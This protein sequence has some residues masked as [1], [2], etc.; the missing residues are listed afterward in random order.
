MSSPDV[1]EYGQFLVDARALEIRTRNGDHV[2]V[3][4]QAVR[5]LLIL[6]RRIGE[7]VTR[8]EIYQELW[9]S[10][11]I[12][13][14]RGLN[15][16]VRQL[17]IGLG[18]SATDPRHIRTYPGRGYRLQ[19]AEPILA[20]EA[21]LAR[22]THVGAPAGG[23]VDAGRT[24][25][26]T[27]DGVASLEVVAVTGGALGTRVSRFSSPTRRRRRLALASVGVIA[28]ACGTAVAVADAREP[29]LT[30]QLQGPMSDDD[31][32]TWRA[33]L[34]AEAA[35]HSLAPRVDVRVVPAG[36]GDSTATL[37]LF[38]EV[39]RDTIWRSQVR[40]RDGAGRDDRQ[41]VAREVMAA[42]RSSPNRESRAPHRLVG[43]PRA[44][45][46][47]L[48]AGRHLLR[49]A[50]SQQRARAVP[51][52][53][54][55]VAE[56]PSARGVRSELAE[57]LLW[58]GAVD[59]AHA[60][61]SAAITLDPDDAGSWFI[62]G[63]TAHLARWDWAQAR[64]AIA[65]AIAL[66]PSRAAFHSALAFV[67][68]TAG[69]KLESSASLERAIATGSSDAVVLADVGQIYA[70]IGDA[71][72]AVEYCARAVDVDSTATSALHC[73]VEAQLATGDSTGALS[74]VRR[75][76]AGRSNSA[77]ADGRALAGELHSWRAAQA[78]DARARL[79]GRPGSYFRA[80]LTFNRAG[81]R[82]EALLALREAVARREPY[83]VMAT[84][85]PALRDLIDVPG[86][87]ALVSPVVAAGAAACD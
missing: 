5:L 6:H 85:S 20:P 75:L 21:P 65:R 83:A 70:L 38:C 2:A 10:S 68:A 37:L 36:A 40:L 8:R 82:E 54:G 61:A 57:A 58:S 28:I 12:D 3:G 31:A 19:P 50:E 1:V 53:A 4:P 67:E 45:A 44:L 64:N 52:L 56:W 43:L 33:E 47:E 29:A 81:Y 22:E 41:R 27:G 63:V 84:V 79:T 23:E 77:R 69:R 86:F 25:S 46:L 18:D 26:C 76:E 62:Y 71:A 42:A 16:L 73:L 24:L 9:P 15:T 48:S 60:V 32:R 30:V 34:L 74:S 80:A 59:S 51:Y 35:R 72:H 87:R 78:R 7:L 55:V 14:N 17:R 66:D 11:E 13:V 49:S 39:E